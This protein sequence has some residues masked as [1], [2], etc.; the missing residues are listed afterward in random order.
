MI[1]LNYLAFALLFP[2]FCFS[3]NS[4]YSSDEKKKDISGSDIEKGQ[5]VLI[6]PFE[7]KLYNSE[8]DQNLN[9]ETKMN[10]NQ[11]RYTFRSG[12]DFSISNTFQK[13]Y[14]VISLMNDTAAASSFLR[15]IYESIG[16]SYDLLPDP[17]NKNQKDHSTEHSAVQNG[18]LTVSTN[19][20]KKFM[21][22]KISNPNLLATLH[23]KYGTEIFVFISQLDLRIDAPNAVSYSSG[24][25]GRVAN[26]HYSIYDLKGKLIAAGM[27]TKNFPVSVNDPKAIVNNYFNTLAQTIMDNYTLAIAPKAELNKSPGK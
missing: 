1:K 5:K 15:Y 10:F 13:K 14:K 16:Y 7:P 12:L 24:N 23:N 21:K 11:I 20:Q 6:I 3:Q 2:V 27:A 18:Q 17:E 9:K 26:I 25:A 8:I 19:D 4:T 22:V